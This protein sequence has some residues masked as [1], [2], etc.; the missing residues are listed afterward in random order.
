MTL[1]AGGAGVTLTGAETARP[2]LRFAGAGVAS[3]RLEVRATARDDGERD[4]EVITVAL[5]D[6]SVPRAG[7]TLDG[8]L[9]RA[10]GDNLATITVA[11]TVL[12]QLRFVQATSAVSEAAGAREVAVR[13]ALSD[14]AAAPLTVQIGRGGDAGA[15]RDYSAPQTLIVPRGA[16][17]AALTVTALDDALDELSETLVL[18]LA[19]GPGYRVGAQNTHSVT[20]LDDD[21][22]AVTL[23][24]P[25]GG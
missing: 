6:L 16:R 21:P 25:G 7:T 19:P 24:A 12:P 8:G 4:D 23:S 1:A 18:R 17:S 3:G 14:V 2:V 13:L 5:G 15:G 9:S 22:V 20:I 10:P 11:D